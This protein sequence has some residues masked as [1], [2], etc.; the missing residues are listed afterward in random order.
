MSDNILDEIKFDKFMHEALVD[1]P[2]FGQSKIQIEKFV[3]GSHC[4]SA[5]QYRQLLLYFSEKYT[6]LKKA[7]IRRKKISAELNIIRKEIET[8]QDQDLR[9][10]Q[11]CAYEDMELDLKNEEKLIV[12]A[13]AECN[14]LYTLIESIPK[15][16]AEEFEKQEL[17]YWSKRLSGEAQL[18]L[19]DRGSIDQGTQKALVDI[20]INPIEATLKLRLTNEEVA[21]KLLGKTS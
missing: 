4:T 10:I 9:T 1:G 2:T 5:R 11:E 21:K 15:A 7:R 16:T 19:M 12:D 3:V 8:L 17:E 14:F 13:I 20:G 6:A 18:Q